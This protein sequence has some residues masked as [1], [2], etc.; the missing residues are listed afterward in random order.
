MT[1]STPCAGMERDFQH[2]RIKKKIHKR[3]SLCILHTGTDKK[4]NKPQKRNPHQIERLFIINMLLICTECSDSRS[5]CI[6]TE[7]EM[8]I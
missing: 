8:K 2:P 1:L 4:P 5:I 7:P 3:K 6:N